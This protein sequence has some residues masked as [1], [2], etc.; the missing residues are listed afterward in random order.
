MA[1]ELHISTKQVGRSIKTLENFNIIK[2]FRLGKKLNNRY[3]LLDKS[4]W[5]DSLFIKDRQSN[6]TMTDGP[7]H[8]KD[9]HSKDTN[10]K[11]EIFNK[12]ETTRTPEDHARYE[13]IKQEIR[14]KLSGKFKMP[15]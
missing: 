5:V 4:E 11:E 12:T 3:A 10:K 9:T 6:H 2:K 15:S 13:K 14:Q 1:E 7:F 8:S